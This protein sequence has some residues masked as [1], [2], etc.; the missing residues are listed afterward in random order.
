MQKDL[1]HTTWDLNPTSRLLD[2]FQQ[3][4]C[5]INYVNKIFVVSVL[6]AI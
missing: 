5:K 6:V 2:I 1:D 3:T 4:L